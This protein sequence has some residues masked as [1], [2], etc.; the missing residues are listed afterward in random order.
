MSTRASLIQQ[1]WSLAPDTLLVAT[2]VAIA[3]AIVGEWV[4][5]V[6]RWPRLVGYAL[7]GTVLA[8]AHQNLDIGQPGIRLVVDAALAVLLFEAGARVNLR[9]LRHN[10]WLLVTSLLESALTALAVIA[11][12][13]HL[14][15]GASV[16]VPLGLMLMAS[17]PAMVLHVANDL[18]ATGQVTERAITLSALNVLYAAVALQLLK[19]GLSPDDPQ[20]WWRALSPVALSFGGSL[21]LA[22]LVGESINHVARRFDL[23]HDSGVLLLALGVMIA[24]VAAKTLQL[25]TLIVPLLAG[26][27]LS[28]R[29]PRPWL[30]PQHFGSLGAALVLG[31]F[32][33]TNASWTPSLIAPALGVAAAVMAAR[34]G[35]K[36][37][38]VVV[39]ARPS[40][41]STRQ[42]LWLSVALAPV[43]VSA[44][45][46]GTELVD[47]QSG[48]ATTLVPLLT[49]CVALLECVSPWLLALALRRAGDVAQVVVARDPARPPR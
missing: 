15:V 35:A 44:L 10:P 47:S 2:V 17:S 29:S 45:V 41:T 27:W 7:V 23:R 14:G 3:A 46:L 22:A 33:I 4:W 16:A 18:R 9:W 5:R 48:L 25:S 6:W 39:L 38:A 34:W 37:L 32:V 31:L 40:G 12:T 28:N 13:L 19:A 21:V 43:S 24:L 36:L 1:P 30:W 20:S 49:A 8:L 42:S 26:M 11:V